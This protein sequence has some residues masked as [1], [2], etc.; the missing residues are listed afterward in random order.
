MEF[1]TQSLPSRCTFQ[2]TVL[3]GKTREFMSTVYDHTKSQFHSQIYKKISLVVYLLDSELV[4]HNI[5]V[6]VYT[7]F[8]NWMN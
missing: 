3:R 7:C 1:Q 2:N 4:A 8:K 5:R 6:K